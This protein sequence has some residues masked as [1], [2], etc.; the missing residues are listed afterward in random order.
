MNDREFF[1]DT[2]RHICEAFPVLG[3]MPVRNAN[4]L[5]DEFMQNVALKYML[6]PGRFL[7]ELEIFLIEKGILPEPSEGAWYNN[8]ENNI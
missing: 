2:L 4:P 7:K 3:D 5:L 1:N 8:E 6:H